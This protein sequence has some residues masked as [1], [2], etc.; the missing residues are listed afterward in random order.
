MFISDRLIFIELHKTGCSHIL[1]IFENVLDGTVVGKHNQAT[2]DLFNESRI[3][4]GSVR[5]P[6]DWYVSLWGF[7]CDGEGGLRNRLLERSSRVRGIG[8]RTAP[9]TA[10]AKLLR[11]GNNSKAWLASYRDSNDPAAFRDWLHMLHDEAY[12]QDIGEGYCDS[13]LRHVAGLMTF[14]YLKLFSTRVGEEHRLNDLSTYASI[15]AWD[16]EQTFVEHFIRMESLEPD[17]F[18]ILQDNSSALTEDSKSKILALPKT[19]TSSRKRNLAKYYDADTV[20]LVFRREQLII[21]KFA[22]SAP[23]L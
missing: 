14:R 4:V 13:A 3:F 8:W 7:G 5:N 19:N 11:H 6:W 2:P 9:L 21:N 17:L 22:Y 12:M 18:R 10:F 23:E 15:E 1:R 16:T 20:D